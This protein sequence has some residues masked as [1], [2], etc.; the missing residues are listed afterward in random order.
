MILKNTLLA[1]IVFGGTLFLLAFAMFSHPSMK[2]DGFLAAGVFA[3]VI[4]AL[5]FW[6]GILERRRSFYGKPIKRIRTM[7]AL[8]LFAMSFVIVMSRVP[9]EANLHVEI[10]RTICMG[11]AL[12]LL[13]VSRFDGIATSF[14]QPTSLTNCDTDEPSD[15]RAYWK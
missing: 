8:V 11:F 3:I 9:G 7:C 10:P 6:I 15:A 4:F 14:D 2:K 13:N 1:W 5:A 12:V